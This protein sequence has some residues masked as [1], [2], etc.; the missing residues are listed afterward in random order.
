MVIITLILLVSMIIVV[1]S[2][3]NKFDDKSIG[4]IQIETIK[5]YQNAEKTLFLIDQA[6]KYSAYKSIYEL[7]ENGGRHFLDSDCGDYLDYS[8]WY[9]RD[10]E[11]YP[12][13]LGQDFKLIYTKN[14]DKLLQRI[15]TI[16]SFVCVIYENPLLK[17]VGVNREM[18]EFPISYTT[19]QSLERKGGFVVIPQT[20]YLKGRAREIDTIVIHYTAGITI[21]DALDV[22]SDPTRQVSA[23]Y[24]M[25]KDGEVVQAVDEKDTAYHAGG[26]SKTLC[27]L[28][29]EYMNS[30]SIGIEV[31]NQGYNCGTLKSDGTCPVGCEKSIKSCWADKAENSLDK[32]Y[33]KTKC[34][35]TPRCWEPYPKEQWGALVKLAADIIRRNP[36][37]KL[38]REHIV[39]HEEISYI[40]NDPG[41]LFDLDKFIE[42]VKKEL[43]QEQ[44]QITGAAIQQTT[45]TYD[46]VRVTHYYTPSE[47]DF[48]QWHNPDYNTGKDSLYYCKIPENKRGFYEEVQCQGSGISTDNKPYSY[49]TI[50]PTQQ[51]STSVN[52]IQ[53]KTG[54]EPQA[55]RTIAVDP[56]MIPYGSKVTIKFKDCKNPTCC[57]AWEGDYIAE[58]RGQTMVDDWSKG[59]A[60]IDLYTGVGKASLQEA[61]CLPEYAELYVAGMPV[62]ESAGIYAVRPSFETT[63][64]YD[65]S[66]YDKIKEGIETLR[67]ECIESGADD[68]KECIKTEIQKLSDSNLKWSLGSCDTG[69]KALFYSFVEAY[70]NCFFSLDDDCYCRANVHT[71]S[72]LDGEYKIHLEDAGVY[73]ASSGKYSQ[74]L[75]GHRYYMNNLGEISTDNMV[76]MDIQL[77]FDKGQIKEQKFQNLFVADKKMFVIY[78]MGD[79]LA[80]ATKV[81]E[82][83]T[84][85]NKPECKVTQDHFQFC[86]ANNNKKFPRADEK[87]KLFMDPVVYKFAVI[88]KDTVPPPKILDLKVTD[89]PIADKSLTLRWSKS[90]AKDTNHYRIYLSEQPFN[91]ITKAENIAAV[92]SDSGIIEANITVEQDDKTYYIAVAAVDNDLNVLQEVVSVAGVSVDDL[93][94]AKPAVGNY[95]KENKKIEIQMPV[96]NIDGTDISESE[97]SVYIRKI[98]IDAPNELD[99]TNP[100]YVEAEKVLLLKGRPGEHKTADIDLERGCYLF[101]AEDE[102]GNVK[103]TKTNPQLAELTDIV[104]VQ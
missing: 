66:D 53:T 17:I 41:P 42:D 101:T 59:I 9:N 69:E 32:N 89:R 97:I 77:K 35:I 2:K 52:K 5:T 88:F 49:I 72:S 1:I 13:N 54:A 37:I 31:V 25:G 93:G 81:A 57:T 74:E 104:M 44:N 22:F 58:D 56:R 98:P 68:I 26:C 61:A 24:I 102:K 30:R 92:K 18:L 62:Q 28:G 38:D 90:E 84:I 6:A 19:E 103:L 99:C 78:K 82:G 96:K 47:S 16:N 8:I 60:H 63:V 86:V 87:G 71:D 85:P 45:P 94:P 21:Q 75:E 48:T 91:D 46:N 11:C 70:N 40:K 65:F 55:H 76:Q 23:H 100:E 36:G 67:Q 80:I 4:E 51:D 73:S 29:S 43:G 7:A 27:T 3:Q 83:Q 14:I 15:T 50:K 20:N 79:K 39:G 33:D 12:K 10:K 64:N 34:E 95:D